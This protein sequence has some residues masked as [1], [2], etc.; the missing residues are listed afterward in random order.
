[1]IWDWDKEARRLQKARKTTTGMGGL[2]EERS[3]KGREEKQLE[4]KGRQLD[5]PHSYK[6]ETRGRT[7]IIVNLLCITENVSEL[8]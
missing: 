8:E 5:Q 3:E 1:M 6:V 4:R 2:C 7:I